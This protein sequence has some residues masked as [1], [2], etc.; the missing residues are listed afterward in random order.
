MF[1][2]A[3]WN[4]NSLRVRLPQVIEWIEQYTPDVIALQETKT[5]DINFPVSEL[6][7]LGYQVVFSGQKTFNGVATLSKHAATDPVIALPDF[8]NTQKR[9]LAV[10]IKGIRVINVYIP[11]GGEIPSE[12]YTYK[13]AWLKKL[14]SFVQSELKQHSKMIILGDYNIA[15]EDRD[16]CDP[17]LFEG[18]VLVSDQVR[19]IF[20]QLLKLGFTDAF[21]AFSE[22]PGF[23]WWD[24]RQGAF[25][26]NQGLRID[27]ILF[28]NALKE[29]FMRCAVDIAPR[30]HVRPSDHAPVVATFSLKGL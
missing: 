14:I 28:S 8:D 29:S 9:L 18:S 6:E 15:P 13:L 27:H 11:N 7:A 24:Y 20:L 4:V 17:V 25:R 3:T 16:V 21:R 22:E 19:H 2:I 26:R 10:T 1:T 12:K 30:K 5:E 23:S